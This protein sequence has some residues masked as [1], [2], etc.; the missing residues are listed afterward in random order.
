MLEQKQDLNQVDTLSSLPIE[1]LLIQLKTSLIGLNKNEVLNKLKLFGP[2][3]F[4]T[5]KKIHPLLQY[6]KAFLS[7]LPIMLICLAAISL[8]TG[9]SNGALIIM[10]MIFLSTTLAFFQEYRSN[11]AAAELKVMVGVSVLVKRDGSQT[12][13]PLH[14]IVPGDIVILSAGDLIPADLRLINSKDLFINQSSLTGEAMP[15]EKN[16]HAEIHDTKSPF[17]LANICFMGSYV[18]SGIATGVVL[19]S[20]KNTYFGKLVKEVSFQNKVSSFDKGI[21]KFIWLMLRVMLVMVPLVFLINGIVKGNWMEALLFATAVAVGLTPEMLPLLV[22]INLAKGA[23]I[24]SKKKVIVKRLASIQNLGAMNILCTDKTGTLTQDQIILE[25]HIDVLGNEDQRI[26][27]FA[28]LN[29]HYQTG[30]KNLL[31][32]AILKHVDLHEKLHDENSYQKIDEIPFDFLRRR[33]SVVLKKNNEDTVLICKGAIEEVMSCCSHV[34]VG[35]DKFPFDDPKMQEIRPLIDNLNS[36]GYRVIAIAIK[37]IHEHDSSYSMIEEENLILLGYIA[38]LDPPKESAKPAIAKLQ[39]I[40]IEVKVLTGDNELVTKKICSEV[41]LPYA[42]VLIGTQLNEMSDDELADKAKSYSIFAKLTPQQKSRIIL[43]LQSKGNVVGFI[44]DGINDGP[45]IK[46]ADVG[47]SVDSAVDIAKDSADII[48]LEKSLLVLYDG[49]LEGRRVFG[50]ILKYIKMS[51]SSNF[52]NMLSMIGASALLPF[53]PMAPI[54]ILLNNFLYDCSQIAVPTDL[55]DEDYLLLPRIWDVRNIARFMFFIGPI[56]SL[57]DYATFAL[58]WF[59]IK[60]NSIEFTSLFQTGWFVESLL[61]Q[62]LIV[63][64]IRTGKIPFLESRP[65]NALLITTFSICLIG[66][67]LPFSRLSGRLQMQP[68]PSVY[69][70]GLLIILLSYFLF[71]QFIKSIL[72]KRFGL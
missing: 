56:S 40:G 41:G 28:Y 4:E 64:V 7:P 6:L 9:E 13:I 42:N 58:M 25:K 22:T 18:V 45:A 32:A 65:S 17:D 50:N 51:A 36:D 49:V 63:H 68:L 38:F 30:L 43:A 57:F 72:V 46:V 35:E 5:S 66:V 52:G 61:S 55:V 59:V 10:I 20:G 69:W 47:I 53:L 70:I 29:S 34:Q 44:G 11:K 48:L 54:Q 33:M 31:D 8:V 37:F 14:E 21:E 67:T 24:M 2:N 26:L 19:H 3:S 71:T 27:E 16:D 23:M 60:A 12:E 39:K 62:T 15:V 1:V